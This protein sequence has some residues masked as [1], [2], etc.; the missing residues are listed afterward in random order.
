M[1][2]MKTIRLTNTEIRLVLQGLK[3]LYN[4][5]SETAKKILNYDEN[6]EFYDSHDTFQKIAELR[7]MFKQMLRD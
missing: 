1:S 5:N 3:D 6:Y 4:H 7:G 2:N